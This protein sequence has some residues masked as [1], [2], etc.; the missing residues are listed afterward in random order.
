MNQVFRFLVAITAFVGTAHSSDIDL[1]QQS[2]YDMGSSAAQG[3]KSSAVTFLTNLGYTTGFDPMIQVTTSSGVQ[4]N[5]SPRSASAAADFLATAGNSLGNALLGSIGANLVAATTSDGFAHSFNSIFPPNFAAVFYD[6]QK[7]KGFNGGAGA[8]AG[9]EVFCGSELVFSFGGGGGGGVADDEGTLGGGAGVQSDSDEVGGGTGCSF[10]NMGTRD[11][12]PEADSGG[13]TF[14]DFKQ[15][16]MDTLHDCPRLTLC[17]GGGG[18]GGFQFNDNGV[19]YFGG[20]FSFNFTAVVSR[21]WGE[22]GQELKPVV[23][24][25][26]DVTC[27]GSPSKRYDQAVSKASTVC[28]KQCAGKGSFYNS[29]YCPCFKSQVMKLGLSW[30]YTMDCNV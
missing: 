6:S 29:C 12:D 2:V 24:M 21:S 16:I 23:S 20:G 1:F 10:S 14:Y 28:S 4:C 19:C 5:A 18:G 7:I 13:E 11:C 30:G 27:P 17:G 9:F 8:G 15:S 25:P 26:T 22:D 3:M